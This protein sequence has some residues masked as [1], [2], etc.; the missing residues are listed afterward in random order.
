MVLTTK[1][2]LDSEDAWY[3]YSTLDSYEAINKYRQFIYY[4]L[5]D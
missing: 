2:G 5:F 4:R 1:D 3:P